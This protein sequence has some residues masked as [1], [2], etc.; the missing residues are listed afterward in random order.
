M[1]ILKAGSDPVPDLTKKCADIST[2]EP[3]L[4]AANSGQFKMYVPP[5]GASFE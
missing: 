2:S 5:A 4:E 3:K 1:R